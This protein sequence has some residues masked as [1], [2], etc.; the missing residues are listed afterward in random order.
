MVYNLAYSY[1]QNIEDAEEI[2]QDVFVKVYESLDTFKGNSKM[3][4]W[5][6]KI[7]INKSLD[8]LKAKNRKKRFAFITSLFYDNEI[9]LKINPADLQNPESILQDKHGLNK[10]MQSILQLPNQQKTAIILHKVQDLPQAEV[11]EI[12]RISTK[13]VGQ[14]IQRGKA[15]L[16]IILKENVE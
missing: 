4:T 13:A 10:L 15:N 8:F 5:L 2:T 7:T 12:M 16:E 9:Q 3:S 11:A 6:Y 14:L 1:A